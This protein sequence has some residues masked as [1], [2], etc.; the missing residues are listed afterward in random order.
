MQQSERHVKLCPRQEACKAL[1]V[2]A[3]R[4][5]CWISESNSLSKHDTTKQLEL[6]WITW[7]FN[8]NKAHVIVSS[9]LMR[10]KNSIVWFTN[11][12]FSH[13]CSARYIHFISPVNPASLKQQHT[14]W[15]VTH[16]RYTCQWPGVFPLKAS[17]CVC[18][19][20][21]RADQGGHGVSEGGGRFEDGGLPSRTL[22]VWNMWG[23]RWSL[24]TTGR[25]EF[26]H[27]SGV[28]LWNSWTAA[29]HLH[30]EQH[31]QLMWIPFTSFCYCQ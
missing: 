16:F 10:Q 6:D 30:C 18:L 12:E 19:L 23:H 7:P 4:S 2:E 24:K 9:V 14:N 25:G 13:Q 5:L 20:R 3:C 11:T 29:P 15:L 27:T 17:W 26:T 21:R 8:S 1:W 31:D 22:A 28:F